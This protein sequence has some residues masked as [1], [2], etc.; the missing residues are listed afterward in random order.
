MIDRQ[1]DAGVQ[2]AEGVTEE[3]IKAVDMATDKNG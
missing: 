1:I 3:E 2:T